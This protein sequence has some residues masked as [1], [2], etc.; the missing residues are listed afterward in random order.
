MFVRPFLLRMQ[1]VSDVSPHALLLPAGFD[2]PKADKRREYLRANITD[3][4]DIAIYS[5]QNSAVLSSVAWAGGLV[6]NP[7]GTTIA[8][9]DRV[10][11]IP[12]SEL[13]D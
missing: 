5:N 7:P 13:L 9:G 1:G 10:R 4:A 12:F 11:Y 6:D 3:N 2:W 8:K